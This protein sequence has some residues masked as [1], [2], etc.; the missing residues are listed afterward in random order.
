MPLPTFHLQTPIAHR[1]RMSGFNPINALSDDENDASL[2]KPV[3]RRRVSK[4]FVP[5]P[6]WKPSTSIALALSRRVS[7]KCG[8]YGDCFELFR[9]DRALFDQL[10]DLRTLLSKMTKLEQDEKDSRL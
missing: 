9:K 2:K 1:S 5:K 8:C 6:V 7:G 4:G 10:V 3:K